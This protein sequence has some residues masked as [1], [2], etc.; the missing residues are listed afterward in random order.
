M[1]KNILICLAGA[2]LTVAGCTS[3][4][5]T[6]PGGYTAVPVNNKEVIA[7]AQFAVKAQE[8]A[9]QE[10][11]DT[12]SVKLKLVKILSARQ[13]V[14]AGMNFRLDVQVNVNGTK[15]EAEVIV[16]WQA[17]RKPDPYKLTSWEWK[18]N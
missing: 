10:K 2:I 9:M 18:K 15:K 16:W 14:V 11:K 6:M 1:K 3:E 4:N 5:K 12:Q 7:A 8:K 17:W 13:Q